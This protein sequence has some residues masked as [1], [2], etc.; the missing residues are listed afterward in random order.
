M[1]ALCLNLLIAESNSKTR[2]LQKT[3]NKGSNTTLYKK[4][5]FI[6]V[7]QDKSYQKIYNNYSKLRKRDL[8]Y[9]EK[10]YES[11]DIN[12]YEQAEA[13]L[14]SKCI[15]TYTITLQK[16]SVSRASNWLIEKTCKK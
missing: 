12:S 2:T 13:L 8:K 10:H 11:Q 1:N 14:S 3:E 16:F 15:E 9:A 6:L 5:I 4:G 7:L